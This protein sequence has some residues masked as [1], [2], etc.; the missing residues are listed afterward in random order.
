MNNSGLDVY[1][2]INDFY[3]KRGKKVNIALDITGGTKAMSAGGAMAGSIIGA[4]VF[5][6]AND[7]YSKKLRCP[8]P[9]SEYLKKIDNP[10]EVFGDIEL[11]KVK[12]L[13][14]KHNYG[15]AVEIISEIKEKISGPEKYISFDIL[16]NLSQAYKAWDEFD[17]NNA[18]KKIKQCQKNIKKFNLYKDY[19]SILEKQ[20]S[21]LKNLKDGLDQDMDLDF[22]TDTTLMTNL[23]FSI[24]ANALRQEE[25]NKF[26]LAALLLYRIVEMMGQKRLA[27]HGI[28]TSNP[29]LSPKEK[30]KYLN[31]MNKVSAEVSALY[32]IEEFP[33]KIAN[34]Q[35]YIL[36]AALDDP[37]VK[38]LNW[39]KYVGTLNARNNSIFAH[40]YSFIKE[41]TY[42]SFKDVV[43][44]LLDS[45][46]QVEGI[47][48]KE[49][50]N[51][52]TFK[53]Y[54]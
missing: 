8:R 1:K 14:D 48:K 46:C 19:E 13:W 36:L 40:G 27:E 9:G 7:N 10:Y 30:E 34:L 44:N 17:L 29:N 18:L 53:K 11:E 23:I 52:C 15:A 39:H 12:T 47:N 4:D 42:K 54:K 5:Y 6:V 3:Q 31:N 41:K 24:Y 51:N 50:L 35:G 26:D 20:E 38:D 21:I 16:L 37:F 33:K 22:L 28:N 49:M 2:E 25:L 43:T 45:F 32:E